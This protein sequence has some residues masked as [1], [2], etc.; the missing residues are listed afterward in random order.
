M[1]TYTE[2][3]QEMIGGF[4]EKAGKRFLTVKTSTIFGEP[5]SLRITPQDVAEFYRSQAPNLASGI[6]S[7]AGLPGDWRPISELADLALDWFKK[8]NVEGMRRAARKV[9]LVPKF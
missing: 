7:L 2:M 5:I 4:V 8:V 3:A 1:T 6:R 9:G